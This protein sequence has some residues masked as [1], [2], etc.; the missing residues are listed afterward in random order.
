MCNPIFTIDTTMTADIYFPQAFELTFVSESE[1][2]KDC[3]STD[4]HLVLVVRAATR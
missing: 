1:P 3:E 2:L 4:S